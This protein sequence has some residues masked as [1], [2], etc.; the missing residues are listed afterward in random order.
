[1]RKEPFNDTTKEGTLG[2]VAEGKIIWKIIK[3]LQE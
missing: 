3:S 2:R 1:M